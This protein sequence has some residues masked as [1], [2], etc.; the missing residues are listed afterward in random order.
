ALGG[1]ALGMFWGTMTVGRLV[2]GFLARRVSYLLLLRAAVL[3]GLFG[4]LGLNIAR[5]VSFALLSLLVLGFGFAPIWP[6]VVA[7]VAKHTNKLQATAIGLTVASGGLGALF[8]PWFMGVVADSIGL[9]RVF[10]VA[11]VLV[12]ALFGVTESPLFRRD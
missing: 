11:L 8:F 2:F 4:L 6:L 1:A 12:V 7:W 5:Q 10:L 9:R 3:L